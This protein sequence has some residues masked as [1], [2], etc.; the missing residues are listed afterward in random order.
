MSEQE[1]EL[2]TEE[3]VLRHEQRVDALAQ[4]CIREIVEAPKPQFKEIPRRAS[5]LPWIVGI[6]SFLVIAIQTPFLI[7][8][9]KDTPPLRIGPYNTDPL[10]D[11]C[12]KN[13][14]QLSRLLQESE[15]LTPAIV[16]PVT[17]KPYQVKKVAGETVVA[18]P[19]PE[20]HGLTA[21]RISEHSPAP[22][23]IP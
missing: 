4:Q 9:L 21:L 23:V 5:R 14:W 19:N 22:E 17:H 20:R 3:E 2:T 11:A 6:V 18:C 8:A 15:P 12:I 1:Q 13:L 10:A 7:A 16:E